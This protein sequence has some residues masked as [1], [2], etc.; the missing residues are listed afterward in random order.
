MLPRHVINIVFSLVG[1]MLKD[2]GIT[3]GAIVIIL[4]AVIIVA[5]ISAYVVTRP[6]ELPPG[7]EEE[8]EDK[9]VFKMAMATEIATESPWYTVIN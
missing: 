3:T 5:G 7:E 9:K 6:E 4:V 2:S 8:E 1:I